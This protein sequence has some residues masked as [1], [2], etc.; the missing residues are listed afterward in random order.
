MVSASPTHM[1][2]CSIK[3]M[4]IWLSNKDS[5]SKRHVKSLCLR[6]WKNARPLVEFAYNN[7]YH[8]SIDMAPYEAL[9][10][11]RCRTP[12]C[13]EEVGERKLSKIEL[14][15]HTKEIVNKI[16]EKLRAAQDN[17]RSMLI[18]GDDH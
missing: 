7:G 11:R 18:P 9:Y 4:H 12:I 10:G 14:I 1:E 6:I 15:D 17:Q 5:N 13:W 16:R 3:G 8:S 2:K